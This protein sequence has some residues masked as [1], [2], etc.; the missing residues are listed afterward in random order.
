MYGIVSMHLFCRSKCEAILSTYVTHD[1]VCLTD[2]S[3]GMLIH[4]GHTSGRM[5]GS[6]ARLLVAP[7]IMCEHVYGVCDTGASIFTIVYGV[8]SVVIWYSHS[9]GFVD[10]P[11]LFESSRLLLCCRLYLYCSLPVDII[12]LIFALFV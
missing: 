2:S 10:S 1:Q 4:L 8:C 5:G 12:V 11:A 6:G 9:P 7:W 3:A